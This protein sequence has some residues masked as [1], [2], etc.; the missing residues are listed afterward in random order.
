LITA[1]IGKQ[2]L[3]S[4]LGFSG[5]GGVLLQIIRKET[6]LEIIHKMLLGNEVH[7]GLPVVSPLPQLARR[8]YHRAE[9][10]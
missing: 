1:S 8:I 3:V 4:Y 2:S 7:L 10:E 6:A 5:S 9:K